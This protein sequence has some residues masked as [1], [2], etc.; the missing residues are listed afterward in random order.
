MGTLKTDLLI[1]YVIALGIVCYLQSKLFSKRT[2]KPQPCTRPAPH[3]CTV[4][5]PCNGWPKDAVQNLRDKGA[6]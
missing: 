2:P 3:I 6:L 5:G 1:G 4:N